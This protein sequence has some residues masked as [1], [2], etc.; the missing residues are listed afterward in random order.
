MAKKLSW[1][2]AAEIAGMSVRNLQRMR[3]R[4]QEYGYTGLFDQRRGKRSIHRIPME[5]AERVLGLYRERYSDWQIDQ[6]RFRNTLA[7]CTVKPM[8]VSLGA[9]TLPR[10]ACGRSISQGQQAKFTHSLSESAATVA[11]GR[12]S[13]RRRHASAN[14]RTRVRLRVLECQLGC[15]RR[16]K[17]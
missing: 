3:Q 2:E 9:D 8:R 6:T 10:P 7:G 4:Y 1:I 16:N 5:T 11:R 17:G 13:A 12:A 15:S 14:T